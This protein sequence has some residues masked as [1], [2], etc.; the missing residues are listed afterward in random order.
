MNGIFKGGSDGHQL[1]ARIWKGIKGTP[2]PASEGVYSGDETWD[3]IHYVQSLA[4]PGAQ[5]R[6][7]LKQGTFV[8]PNIRGPLPSSPTDGAWGQARPLYIALTP[9]WWT[10]DRIEGLVV[11][12]VHNDEDLAI[13]LS[14]LDPTRDERAVRQ[15][16]FRDGVAIQFSLSSVR[17]FIWGTA[18]STAA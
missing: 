4:R 13:R 9:L 8:A 5:E 10:E 16:E 15:N 3:I 6:A 1:Y 17:L 7:Q 14:W 12:A 2:M 11:Q 18:A